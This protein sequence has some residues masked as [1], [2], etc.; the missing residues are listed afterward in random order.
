LLFQL[1][2]PLN[3]LGS[4][5]RDI[6]QSLVDM[7]TLFD[8]HKVSSRI[9]VKPGAFPLVLSPGDDKAHVIFDNV[10]FNYIPGQNILNGLTFSVP[11]GKR[12]A[13]VGGS[14]SGKSTIVRLLYRFYDPVDGRILVAGHDIQDLTMDSLRKVVGVVPQDTVLFHD[15][16]FYNINYGRID[17]SRD[18]VFEAA[19]MAEIHEAVL[20]MPKGY[21]TQVGERGLK[22]SGGEKQRIAIAR[23]ILKNPPIL[24]YD[25]ATSSLDS[26]TE[27]NILNSLRRVT[28]D[29]TSIFIAHRLS[30]VVDADEILVLEEGRVRERGS[31]YSLITDRNS[32]YAHLWHKQH[33]AYKVESHDRADVSDGSSASGM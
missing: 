6:R 15:D 10:V 22:L 12:V 7:Q 17:A 28:K 2:V 14:G 9:K 26:I 25:E 19:K 30:T 4:V 1:S 32:L 18:E 13:I 16:V 33:E 8:L 29:R 27:M 23:A 5:Y 3:F 21:S 20:R 24:M 11:A 31:H